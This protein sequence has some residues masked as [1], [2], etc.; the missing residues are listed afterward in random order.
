M[1]TLIPCWGCTYTA[2]FESE[3][4]G[5]TVYIDGVSKGVTPL[6][7]EL[8]NTDE[9][10]YTLRITLAGHDPVTQVVSPVPDGGSVT[11]TNSYGTADVQA[12]TYTRATSYDYGN[13]GTRS[14]AT[15]STYASAA[16]TTTT[17]TNTI[18]TYTWPKR[19]FFK[20][21]PSS[22]G[23]PG[24]G[25]TPATSSPATTSPPPWSPPPRPSE[26]RAQPAFCG[27]CGA[28]LGTGVLFCGGCGAK[29]GG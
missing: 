28:R 4:P 26:A 23:S 10:S 1:L 20:L 25:S 16:G 24:W 18:P 22:S 8:L 9:G 14:R 11:F 21:R 12:T 2:R 5:A 15:T 6:E 7:L 19:F 13:M 17:I 3:P 29:V 27:Q